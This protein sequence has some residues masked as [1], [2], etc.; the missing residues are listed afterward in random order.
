[1]LDIT[2]GRGDPD[3]P[4]IILGTTGSGTITIFDMETEGGNDDN[5]NGIVDDCETHIFIRGDTDDSGHVEITDAIS[6]L[7]F[8]FL[9]A[10]APQSDF[11][12]CGFDV[13]PDRLSCETYSHCQ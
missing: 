12:L 6:L 13:T 9:G 3:F 7:N 4:Q 2:R 1:M 10:P 8:L 5:F 11:H